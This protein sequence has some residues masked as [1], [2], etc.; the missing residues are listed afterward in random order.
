[1]KMR[2]FGVALLLLIS[3]CGSVYEG[4]D[5]QSGLR[6]NQNMVNSVEPIKTHDNGNQVN[7]EIVRRGQIT[8]VDIEHLFGLLQ[9]DRVLLLDC[10]PRLFYLL[11]HID[12]ALNLPYRNYAHRI[13]VIEEQL[14]QA[15]AES[16]VLVVYCQ[17]YNCPDAY[18]FAEK[19]AAKGY[20]C[21]V[22]K[23]GWQEWK[24]L[25]L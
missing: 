12:Q 18:R 25:G 3:A 13:E 2:F 21:S 20:S 23:G 11:G 22:Y 6:K 9:A 15:L 4:H 1:M 5:C 10:R 17:N 7:H 8:G 24:A 16:Q 14:D 19:M